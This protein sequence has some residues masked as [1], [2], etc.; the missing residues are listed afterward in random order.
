M[1]PY[2][3]TTRVRKLSGS[4]RNFS[5]L[6]PGRRGLGQGGYWEGR[7]MHCR[8][9][10]GEGV[11]GSPAAGAVDADLNASLWIGCYATG[12]WL[13]ALQCFSQFNNVGQRLCRAGACLQFGLE[14]LQCF[15]DLA[16]ALQ[17]QAQRVAIARRSRLPRHCC[18][19]GCDRI[20][21]PVLVQQRQ[22]KVVRGITVVRVFDGSACQPEFSLLVAPRAV[23]CVA[24][25]VNAWPVVWIVPQPPP[26]KRDRL[27]LLAATQQFVA[28][29]HR[30]NVVSRRD[31]YGVPIECQV[32]GVRSRLGKR[33]DSEQDNQGAGSHEASSYPE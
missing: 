21:Q 1:S 31:G 2:S 26:V 13:G 28:Q 33:P 32:A 19:Q 20:F 30:G 18:P 12:S 24:Q 27:C 7:F 15:A 25:V 11:N 29:V 23:V 5:R 6:V 3:R 8:S 17:R 9:P 22:T 10:G 16:L 14:H 4:R